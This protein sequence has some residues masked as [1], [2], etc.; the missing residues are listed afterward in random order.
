MFG[1]F[2]KKISLN[3]A[4]IEN[5]ELNCTI[6]DGRIIPSFTSVT[7]TPDEVKDYMDLYNFKTKQLELNTSQIIYVKN[8]PTMHV[9]FLLNKKARLILIF[10]LNKIQ[11]LEF[12]LGI[13]F[14][15]G[16]IFHDKNDFERGFHIRFANEN[17][18]F[19]DKM[20]KH[21]QDIIDKLIHLITESNSQFKDLTEKKLEAL[22]NQTNTREELYNV[23]KKHWQFE[24]TATEA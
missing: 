22:K 24:K 16:F 21:L 4:C 19:T 6:P 13:Y 9:G 11:N 12:I 18:E 5:S 23:Y 7:D 20:D 14:A 2:S 1:L 10:D 17:N 8:S 3:V 15:Q